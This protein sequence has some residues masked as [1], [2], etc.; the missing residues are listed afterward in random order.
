M[1]LIMVGMAGDLQLSVVDL[2]SY[3]VGK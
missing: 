1:K 2:M 3:F